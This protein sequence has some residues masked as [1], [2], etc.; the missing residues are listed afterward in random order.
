[1]GRLKPPNTLLVQA[2]RRMRSPSGSGR[3]M[4]RQE[5]A[6][7][8]NAYLWDTHRIKSA[9]DETDV[10]RLERGENRW[11]GKDRREAFRAVLHV[12]TDADIGF[13]INRG[14]AATARTR[15]EGAITASLINALAP[16]AG[17]PAFA[18]PSEHHMGTSRSDRDTADLDLVEFATVLD[19]HGLSAAELTAAE[20]ACEGIDRGFAQTP[21][22]ELLAKIRMLM[23]HV[24][25]RLREPQTLRHHERLVRLAARLAGLRAWTCFD[26]D[27]HSAADRWYDGAVTAAQEAKAW[28][29]GAWLLGA[30]SLIPW[31]RRDLGQAK[32]LIE[33]GIYFASQGSDATTRA[34]LH[35]L[36]ARSYAGMGNAD[37]FET[38][39]ASAQEA[40]EYS[41]ERDR[42]H[43]M[44]FAYGT[45]DLRYYHG[46][47][48]LLLQQPERAEAELTGSLTDLPESHAKA[49]A[50]LSLFLADAAVQQ[51]D[52]GRAADLTLHALTSTIGQPIMPVLQQGRRIH[53][54]LTQRDPMV[55]HHLDDA[56][57]DF[58]RAL[59]TIASKATR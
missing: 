58:S 18:G 32:E 22:D 29:L 43:G 30:H 17:V 13:Y 12:E 10:G 8:V 48:R 25:A 14:S 54:I 53:R 37:G 20:L 47:S 55:G 26:I 36:H 59:T 51:D 5:L 49:R 28:G 52:V 19:Q 2:R 3:P 6:H 40:A 33:R 1:M 4:S 9:L 57:H 56:M 21:P 7:A 35:A 27:D 46:T 34:W 41:N 16:G 11:P 44:D 15:T 42:H 23:R 50:V 38:A 31:H 24:S 45:L 39:Y